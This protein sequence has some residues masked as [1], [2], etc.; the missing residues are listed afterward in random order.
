MS[1]ITAA[2]LIASLGWGVAAPATAARE[3]PVDVVI[4]AGVTPE[5]A[6]AIRMRAAE[7]KTVLLKYL[8]RGRFAYEVRTPQVTVRPVDV[9]KTK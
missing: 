6:R 5:A 9:P 1:R 2:A 8:D 7:G 3:E 4:G